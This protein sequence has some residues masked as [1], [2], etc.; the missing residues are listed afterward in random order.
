MLQRIQRVPDAQL[1][2]ADDRPTALS[3][4]TRGAITALAFFYGHCVDP[5]GCPV[6]WSSFETLRKEA[7]TIRFCA[8]G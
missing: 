8:I 7:A 3:V 6:A 1:L 4:A 2:D 5:A